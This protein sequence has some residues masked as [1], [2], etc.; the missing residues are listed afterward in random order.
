MKKYLIA[1]VYTVLLALF[2][3]YTVMDTFKAGTS[4]D[5]DLPRTLAKYTSTPTPVPAL[6]VT[7]VVTATPSAEASHSET[8]TLTPT[9]TATPT[10]EPTWSADGYIDSNM[11]V[12]ISRYREYESDIYVVDAVVN[13]AD[14]LKTAIT[15]VNKRGDHIWK[16]VSDIS[17][18]YGDL[19]ISIN[20]DCWGHKKSGYSIKNGVILRDTYTTASNGFITKE[21]PRQETLVLWADGSASIVKEGDY[22]AQ[23]LIDKGAWQLFNFGPALI[24]DGENVAKTSFTTVDVANSRHPRTAIGL[25]D[26]L[27]YVFIIVDGRNGS[28]NRGV[29]CSQLAEFGM[30]LGIKYLYNLDGG[31]S[32][33]L[34]F[35][36]EV[37][38]K[39]CRKEGKIGEVTVTDIVYIGY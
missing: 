12:K 24:N 29:T 6:T 15:G 31:G 9:P 32:A 2:T 7:P 36:G 4:T 23:E 34:Y 22:T 30:S 16:V 33:T 35:Q 11:S 27:H 18:E 19:I 8:L 28:T 3:L 13:S 10:I 14:L 5:F 25:K 20:G 37:L 21:E 1:V 26:D 17:K 39:P 38:N